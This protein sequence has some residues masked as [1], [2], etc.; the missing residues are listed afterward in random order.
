MAGLDRQQIPH[1]HQRQMIADDGGPLAVEETEDA[2]VQRE[3]AFLDRQADA[4]GGDALRE[5][6]H[7]VR[8]RRRVRPPPA[9]GDHAAVAGQH[10]AVQF[11]AR[12]RD[13]VEEAADCGG[14]DA[15]PVRPIA[16]QAVQ[17]LRG[18]EGGRA[19]RG[20]GTEEQR[21]AE[22]GGVTA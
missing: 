10:E 2:I 11:D 1:R 6:V 7:H 22:L 12:A 5:R 16:E 18:R 14:V 17:R 19:A 21:S 4:A 15:L 13:V 20:Q 3:P 9:L 8:S